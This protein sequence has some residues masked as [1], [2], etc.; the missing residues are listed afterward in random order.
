[1]QFDQLGRREFITLLGG[2]A[3]WPLEARAEKSDRVRR[4]GVIMGFAQND[5]V[6]RPTSPRS[7][8]VC[9]NLA[10]AMAAIFA[11]T[12]GS[13]AKAPNACATWPKKWSRSRPT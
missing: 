3:A 7:G 5:E 4:V 11:S 1:M 13:P 6:G 9:R 8:R 12:T 10:G 2:A